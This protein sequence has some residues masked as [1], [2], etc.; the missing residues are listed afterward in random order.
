MTISLKKS[1]AIS[2]VRIAAMLSIVLC[3]IFQSYDNPLAWRF[4][5]GVQVFFVLSGYLYGHKVIDNWLKWFWNRAKKLY[6]PCFIYCLVALSVLNFVVQQP[7][8]IYDY[9]T[10]RAVDG[11][12]HL[13]FMKAIFLCYLITPVLSYLRKWSL[14]IYIL[15]ILCGMT[16]FC[17]FHVQQEYFSWMWLYAMGY[18]FPLLKAYIQKVLFVVFGLLAIFVS[19]LMEMPHDLILIDIWHYTCGLALCLI[20]I[21]LFSMVGGVNP[22]IKKF[23]A[24]SFPIYITHHIYLVGP[25]SLATVF[26]SPWIAISVALILTALSSITLKLISD[27]VIKLIKI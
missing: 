8:T 24:Y 18:F 23:D 26:G 17:F 13:W 12:S 10:I 5:V 19:V 4:N 21:A 7:V 25:L 15:L 6:I 22:V 16:E 2:I 9:I 14:G 27:Y 20:P 3:H 11:L 1:N